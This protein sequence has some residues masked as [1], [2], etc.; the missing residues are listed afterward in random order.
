MADLSG[1]VVLITAAAQGI[2][3]ASAE[4]FVRAGATVHATDINAGGLAGLPCATRRL[5]VLD[6]GAIGALVAG[7]Q[8]ERAVKAG[9]AGLP[10]QAVAGQSRAHGFAPVPALLSG[11]R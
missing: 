3:R 6:A 1:Q 2:G 10:H 9:K 8:A 7:G 11:S 4:A 5:D